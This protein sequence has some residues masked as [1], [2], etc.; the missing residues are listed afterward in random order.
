MKT[1]KQ[2]ETLKLAVTAD[3][4]KK[5]DG[6]LLHFTYDEGGV[7]GGVYFQKDEVIPKMLIIMFNIPK[8]DALITQVDLFPQEDPQQEESEKKE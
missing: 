8:K 1:F 5:S 4:D 7:K 3:F 6:K 2:D